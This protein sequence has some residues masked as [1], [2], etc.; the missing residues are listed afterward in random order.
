MI[1]RLVSRAK[2]TRLMTAAVLA[3]TLVGGSFLASE[4]DARAGGGKS[5]GSRGTRSYNYDGGRPLERSIV[6]PSTTRPS[7][8]AQPYGTPGQTARPLPQ[9]GNSRPFLSGLAGGLLGVGLAS[10]LFGSGFGGTAMGGMFGLLLQLML[11]GGLVWLVLRVL[12]GRRAAMAG[13]MEGPA[14]ANQ[15]MARG[16][17]DLGAGRAGGSGLGIGRRAPDRED[18]VPLEL[19]DADFNEFSGLLVRV[20]EAWSAGD[21]N[22]LRV[23]ATPEMVQYL[24]ED[25]AEHASRGVANRVERTRFLE[26][27]SIESW[28]EQDRDYATVRMRWSAFDYMVRIDQPD[29]VIEGDRN[30]ISEAEEVW[31][32][33]RQRPNGR[34]LLSA[35][36][37]VDAPVG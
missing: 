27:Q 25:L 33:M 35:I 13:P 17:F 32:F 19:K 7:P 29:V 4:A 3:L 15:P 11:I 14:V 12:R 36:Q 2:P 16:R 26:G 31:T 10:M 8:S 6:P 37:Q 30:Q 28:S 24:G 34:W 22:A 9:A 20:Q 18:T 23:I 21:L 1:H 5:Y